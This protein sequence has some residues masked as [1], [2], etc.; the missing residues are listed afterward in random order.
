MAKTGVTAMRKRGPV[1]G[2]TELRYPTPLDQDA[3]ES[4]D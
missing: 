4:T 3:E 2:P 1:T